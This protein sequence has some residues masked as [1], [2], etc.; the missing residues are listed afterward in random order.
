MW[1]RSEPQPDAAAHFSEQ[2]PKPRKGGPKASTLVKVTAGLVLTLLAVF[3]AGFWLTGG[4]IVIPGDSTTEPPRLRNQAG[5]ILMLELI[6]EARVRHGVPP[7]V[8]GTNDVAQ[9]Q[10]EALLRNCAL[11]HWGTDGLKP[12]MR[13]SLAGGYQTN[14]ENLT[15]SNE[16]NLLDGWLQWNDHPEEMVRKSAQSLLSSPSHRETLLS[17]AY[18]QVS[19]GLAWDHHTFKVV[20]HFEGDY[21]ELTQ[22][23]AFSKGDLTFAGRLTEN[24]QFSMDHPLSIHIYYDPEPRAL[25]QGQLAQTS[26]YSLGKIVAKVISPSPL[27]VQNFRLTLMEEGPQCADPYEIGADARRPYTQADMARVWKERR[28]GSERTRATGVTLQIM[29][30]RDMAVEGQ[31]FTVAADVGEL[32]EEHGPGVYTVVLLAALE[33]GREYHRQPIMEYAIFRQVKTPGGNGPPAGGAQ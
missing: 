4:T 29:E 31:E 2:V 23:P 10:A 30:A 17:P 9:I 27:F 7:V 8:M 21:V 24:Y 14:K 32:V 28:E 22:V 12:Y 11:S 3:G 6:N 20:Q 13:Y 15:T 5:K 33:G 26:C 25:T 16:C 1:H 18:R 19:L